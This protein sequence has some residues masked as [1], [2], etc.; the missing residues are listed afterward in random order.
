[1]KCDLSFDE[2]STFSH[3]RVTVFKLECQTHYSYQNSSY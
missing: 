3:T 1:M 2:L